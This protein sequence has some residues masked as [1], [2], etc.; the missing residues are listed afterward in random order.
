LKETSFMTSKFFV[1]MLVLFYDL[2]ILIVDYLCGFI[3]RNISNFL[4]MIILYQQ[5]YKTIY[6]Y[7]RH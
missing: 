1:F 5:N 4:K 7:L 3:I 2:A 6:I